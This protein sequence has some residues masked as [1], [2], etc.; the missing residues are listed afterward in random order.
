MGLGGGFHVRPGDRLLRGSASTAK[1]RAGE[2]R[3]TFG[4]FDIGLG[5]YLGTSMAPSALEMSLV[6]SHPECCDFSNCSQ[7]FQCTGSTSECEKG[8]EFFGE[9][10][11]RGAEKW[12]IDL[13]DLESHVITDRLED[14]AG[15]RRFQPPA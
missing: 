4:E 10:G 14:K 12:L 15:Y 3:K 11:I 8:S 2:E 7:L 6:G 9:C 1:H 13:P 5:K